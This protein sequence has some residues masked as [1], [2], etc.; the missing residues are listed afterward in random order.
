MTETFWSRI[1]SSNLAI[2]QQEEKKMSMDVLLQWVEDFIC[3]TLAGSV[4]S[5]LI[6]LKIPPSQGMSTYCAYDTMEG[7]E[8]WETQKWIKR[9]RGETPLQSEQPGLLAEKN[10]SVCKY[11]WRSV[12]DTT[13]TLE[14]THDPEGKTLAFTEH[15]FLW[16][17][18]SYQQVSKSFHGVC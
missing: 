8:R 18:R 1:L 11:L 16:N 4:P 9:E 10:K 3:L 13:F 17:E 7:G 6:M 15:I 14:L 12:R 5:C 2:M